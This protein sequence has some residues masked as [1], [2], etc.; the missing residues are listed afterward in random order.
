MCIVSKK[1]SRQG[2]TLPR[3]KAENDPNKQIVRFLIFGRFLQLF[4]SS[5]RMDKWSSEPTGGGHGAALP[6]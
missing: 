1:N 2:V 4:I 3:H 6:D 5:A